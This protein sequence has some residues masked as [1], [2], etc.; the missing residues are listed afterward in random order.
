MFNENGA[1][2][3][4]ETSGESLMCLWPQIQM[5][6]HWQSGHLHYIFIIYLLC[7]CAAILSQTMMFLN[8]KQVDFVS[9]TRAE[10]WKIKHKE[11]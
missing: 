1:G 4:R 11:M 9:K 10:K 2:C 3:L 6:F 8:P 5:F 7:I